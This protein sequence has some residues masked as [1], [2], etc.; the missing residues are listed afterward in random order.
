MVCFS[1]GLL[2]VTLV[3]FQSVL[4]LGGVAWY[5]VDDSF[6][7][8]SN[9]YW[10]LSCPSFEAEANTQQCCKI[11]IAFAGCNLFVG[12]AC[13]LAKCPLQHLSNACCHHQCSVHAASE[14]GISK[15][16]TT[17]VG[18]DANNAIACHN[19]PHPAPLSGS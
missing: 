1:C 16:V 6:R 17:L 3:W 13:W 18:S 5:G 2:L 11:S 19:G 14:L 12:N 8:V 4:I 10:Y 9:G 7:T 15:Q